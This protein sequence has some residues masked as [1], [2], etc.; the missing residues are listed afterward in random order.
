MKNGHVRTFR[1]VVEGR[2]P[3]LREKLQAAGIEPGTGHE[4]LLRALNAREAQNVLTQHGLRGEII[5]SI[6]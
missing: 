1:V 4:H 2:T 6:S 3:G 5:G